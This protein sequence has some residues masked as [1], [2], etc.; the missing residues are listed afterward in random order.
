MSKKL[1]KILSVIP[2]EKGINKSVAI[3]V[4]KMMEGMGQIAEKDPENENN[5]SPFDVINIITLAGATLVSDLASEAVEG[6]GAEYSLVT[7]Y[8]KSA[9]DSALFMISTDFLS[10]LDDIEQPEKKSE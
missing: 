8:A 10:L 3:L 5:L 9:I 7:E 1:E 6:D 2:S 4:K